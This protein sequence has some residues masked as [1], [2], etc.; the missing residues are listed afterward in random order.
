MTE[1]AA[2][3]QSLVV[4]RQI[5]HPPERI[6]RALTQAPL[7]EEWLMQTDFEP[8][9]GRRFN[10]RAPPMPYWNGVVDGEVLAVEPH[11][12]LAYS[13]AASGE[14][15]ADGLK[16][17]VTWTLTPRD[18]GTHVRMEQSGFRPQDQ[19]NREGAAHGWRRNLAGLEQVAARLS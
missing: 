11:T 8:V 7:I 13:W 4:E 14:E 12:R 17:V 2:A 16:T 9:V 10:F 19:N 3:T 5:P 18:G 6:W 15:A 1:P